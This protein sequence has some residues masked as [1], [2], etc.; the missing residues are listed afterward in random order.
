MTR[1]AIPAWHKG[2]GHKGPM[3]E[4]RRWKGPE[5]NSGIK[6]QGARQQLRLG[7]KGIQQDR[8]VDPHVGGHEGSSWD[9]QQVAE[10]E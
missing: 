8:Q 5:C 7:S 1:H 9:F 4:K 2:C 10:S 6:D 3:A